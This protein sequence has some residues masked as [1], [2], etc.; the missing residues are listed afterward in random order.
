M[1]DLREDAL[2]LMDYLGIRPKKR[3]GQNFLISKEAIK[4][5][6]DTADI[7][8]EDVVIEMGAGL[9]FLSEELVRRNPR[10]LILVEVDR[11][12]CSYLERKFEGKAEVLCMDMMSLLPSKEFSK[13]VSV[14][15]YNISSRLVSSL[16]KS[17]FRKAVLVLQKE[18]VGKLKARPGTRKY[19]W[20]SVLSQAVFHIEIAGYIS[21]FN[22]IPT[23][24]V[25]SLIISLVPKGI[26][27]DIIE[28]LFRVVMAAFSKRRRKIGKILPI[29]DR[30]IAE[31]RSI[32]LSPDEFLEIALS[33]GDKIERSYSNKKD[34]YRG[35]SWHL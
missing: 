27:R 5:I 34:V 4:K 7:S 32:N 24:K 30:R 29:K 14:P 25:D 15:P 35:S 17:D 3:L 23:P 2:A 13:I 18:F 19:T 1:M 20:I 26:S 33:I 12:I 22:F 16:L 6:C 9:G 21:R 11:K 31:K 10:K 28:T 8:S